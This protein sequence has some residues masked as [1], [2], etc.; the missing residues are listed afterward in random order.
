MCAAAAAAAAGYN[1]CPG[2]NPQAIT[3]P[4][5]ELIR[6]HNAYS[7]LKTCFQHVFIYLCNVLVIKSYILIIQ[8]YILD[9][10]ILLFTSYVPAGIY[11]PASGG[12]NPVLGT[13][14]KFWVC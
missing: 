2:S 14:F 7:D 9:I 4:G 12:K 13:L 10:T 3:C 11:S 1:P 5:G 8:S 6:S